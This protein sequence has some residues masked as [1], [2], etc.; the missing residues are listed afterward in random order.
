MASVGFRVQ[1]SGFR[2]QGSGFTYASRERP[3]AV[4]SDSHLSG[5]CDKRLLAPSSRFLRHV[6]LHS[7]PS[8]RHRVRMSTCMISQEAGW[9][10]HP[11]QSTKGFASELMEYAYMLR[12]AQQCAWTC[13]L[14]CGSTLSRELGN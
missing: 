4:H 6:D 12:L 9:A 11:T 2:V 8:S 7:C 13:M 3:C 1:G 5:S 10:H 14:S